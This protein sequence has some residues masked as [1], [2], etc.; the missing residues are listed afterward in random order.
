MPSQMRA[1]PLITS[2]RKFVMGEARSGKAAVGLD[3]DVNEVFGGRIRIL[4]G[5][6]CLS[7]Y[8]IFPKILS[9]LSR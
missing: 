7:C 3:V 8:H 9:D 1:G 5:K 4:E 6:K 2:N